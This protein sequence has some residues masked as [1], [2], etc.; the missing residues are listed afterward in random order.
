MQ[1]IPYSL[2][3]TCHFIFS[4]RKLT[5][6]KSATKVIAE[7]FDLKTRWREDGYRSDHSRDTSLRQA[8]RNCGEHELATWAYVLLRL[9]PFSQSASC[10]LRAIEALLRLRWDTA[11]QPATATAHVWRE[12]S[13]FHL[14]YF[15]WICCTTCF[16][17]LSFFLSLSLPSLRK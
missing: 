10:C 14:V 3:K 11:Q 13:N 6:M 1:L 9:R 15:L 8:R 4:L 17:V 2:I 5:H 16:A 12:T 7:Q